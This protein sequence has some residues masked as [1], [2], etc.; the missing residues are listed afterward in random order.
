MGVSCTCVKLLTN[1]LI[2]SCELHKN[3]F[4]GRAIELPLLC[5]R[6][7]G[8]GREG[9]GKKKLGIMKDGEMRGD[10]RT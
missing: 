5:S 7:K 1:L 6:Y 4:G 3:A 2:L 9:M 10:G 8:E